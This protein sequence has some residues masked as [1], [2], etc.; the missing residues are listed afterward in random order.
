MEKRFLE[1]GMHAMQRHSGNLKSIPDVFDITSLDVIIFHHKKIRGEGG[2]GTVYAA[3]WRGTTV[4]VKV[5]KFDKGT[6]TDVS[7]RRRHC[8]LTLLTLLQLFRKEV[9]IW[10]HLRHPNILEFFG[11]C[12][13]AD[14]P[15]SCVRTQI[16]RGRDEFLAP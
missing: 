15:F 7:C 6:H 12:P 5:F 10:K 11:A 16:T 8:I 4:A 3:D 14:P 13:I 2:C 9:E 1:V